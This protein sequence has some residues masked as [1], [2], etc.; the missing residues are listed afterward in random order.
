[1]IRRQV[2]PQSVAVS[3]NSAQLSRSLEFLTNDAFGKKKK[4]SQDLGASEQFN[5]FFFCGLIHGT[6]IVYQELAQSNDSLNRK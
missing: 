4:K 5:L 3:Y 1:M 2:A 6:W